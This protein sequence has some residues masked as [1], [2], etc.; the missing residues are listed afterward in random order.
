MR[1]FLLLAPLSIALA[2]CGG[3][4]HAASATPPPA[5]ASGSMMGSGHMGNMEMCPMGVPGTQIA[6]ADV[7]GGIGVTFTTS[8][9]VADLRARVH[10]M[11]EMH[12]SRVSGEHAGMMS[13]MHM[14][15]VPSRA[16]AEDIDGGARVVLTPNDPAQLD[17]LR[18][19]AN[20]H[21]D[22]M[23]RGECPMMKSMGE[24]PPN[25]DDHASH[26]GGGM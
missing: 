5:S 13:G 24:P 25:G 17:A 22:M 6:V 21:A 1:T 7:D 16:V 14:Q 2:A 23:R 11:A 26:H 10:P 12:A 8:G 18:A 9:D 3:G 15:M 4:H 20:Q 19:Q